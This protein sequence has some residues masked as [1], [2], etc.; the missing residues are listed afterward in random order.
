MHRAERINLEGWLLQ[1][2]ERAVALP[3]RIP[4]I[5]WSCGVEGLQ[6][7]HLFYKTKTVPCDCTGWAEQHLTGGGCG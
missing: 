2:E 3:A 1:L 4:E 5:Q 6:L 7:E